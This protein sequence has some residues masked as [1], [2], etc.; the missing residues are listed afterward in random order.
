ML[1]LNTDGVNPFHG[2]NKQRSFW[3][4]MFTNFN[5]PKNLRTKADAF[6]LYGVVPSQLDRPVHG[7]APDLTAYQHHMIDELLQLCSVEIY[8]EYSQA[9]VTVIVK[10]LRYMTVFPG[11]TMYFKM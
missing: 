10:T 2:Q 4:L 6:L 3:P 9:P 5:L 7:V 8:S 1:G 11:Y